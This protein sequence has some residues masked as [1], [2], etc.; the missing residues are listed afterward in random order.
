[1]PPA[2]SGRTDVRLRAGRARQRARVASRIAKLGI[3][4]TARRALRRAVIGRRGAG[5][6]GAAP[7]RDSTCRLASLLR[8]P[9]DPA[10]AGA[11]AGRGPAA[12]E[13]RRLGEG[14]RRAGWRRPR[15][16]RCSAIAISKLTSKSGRERARLPHPA[17]GRANRRRARRG[18]GRRAEEVRRQ[19]GAARRAA[20]PRRSVGRPRAAAGLQAKLQTGVSMGATLLGA[21]LGRKAVSAGTLGRATTAARGVGRSM[22]EAADIKRAGESVEAVRHR[23][24]RSSTSRLPRETSQ[25]IAGALRTDAPLERLAADARSAARSRCSSSRSAGCRRRSGR[26][27]A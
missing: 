2:A 11:G 15:R 5:G 13:L 7:Q 6:L 3:D 17:A 16:S 23:R 26:G 19:A 4:E 9:A 1:M 20:A 8:T 14:V 22:K 10:H 18:G 27:P 25:R 24:S 21:L 12:E